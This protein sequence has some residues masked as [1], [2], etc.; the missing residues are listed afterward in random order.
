METDDKIFEIYLKESD[1]H[2]AFDRNGQLIHGS[3]SKTRQKSHE[4]K[5]IF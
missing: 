5:T 1:L 3:D 4:E 2:I